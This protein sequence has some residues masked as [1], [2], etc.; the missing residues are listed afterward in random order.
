MRK[1]SSL[2]WIYLVFLSFFG[3]LATASAQ[4]QTPDGQIA[5]FLTNPTVTGFL[6]TTGIIFMFL[7]VVTM[8]TGVAEVG[9]F[10]CFALMFGGRYLEGQEIWIP[11]ALFVAGAVF[12]L[13][14]VFI[15]PGFGVFGVLSMLSFAWLSVL[16]MDG[17]AAGLGIFALSFLLTVVF[18]FLLVKFMPKSI[19]T[20]KFLIL[21]PPKSD[22]STLKSKVAVPLVQVGD[23][24]EAATTLRPIGTAL[25]GN[26]RLEVLSEGEFLKKGAAIEV[27]RVEGQ[28]VVVRS[29]QV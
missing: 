10:A 20:R 29:C 17:P 24:G 2:L 23:V 8:G 26:Q 6:L 15:I 9:C 21:E 4:S 1:N 13:V 14:E 16:L 25:F 18:T 22:S 27:V 5:Q 12:A 11:L 3:C 7:S 19:V 28:K